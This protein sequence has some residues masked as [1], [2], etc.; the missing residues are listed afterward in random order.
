MIPFITY[1]EPDEENRLCF[2]ILQKAFPHYVGLLVSSPRENGLVNAPIPGY[3][4][5]ITYAGCLHGN[6]FP[7]H[8]TAIA[9]VNQVF[10]L[11]AEWYYVNRIKI[12]PKKYKGFKINETSISTG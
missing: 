1:R 10:N 3:K 11:M 5:W 12:Q 9:E 8:S 7:G 6:F 4:L 2:Y